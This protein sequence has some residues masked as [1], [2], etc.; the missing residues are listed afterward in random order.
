MLLLTYESSNNDV[1][2]WMHSSE[3]VYLCVNT[4]DDKDDGDACFNP[5]C[6]ENGRPNIDIRHNPRHVDEQGVKVMS[7]DRRVQRIQKH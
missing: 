3:N 2:L 1:V 5:I 6:D 4:K 7:W